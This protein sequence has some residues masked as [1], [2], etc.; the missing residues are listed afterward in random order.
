MSLSPSRP[1]PHRREMTRRVIRDRTGNVDDPT[2]PIHFVRFA[3]KK[4][5]RAE[6]YSV[7]MGRRTKCTD[8][9]IE[10]LST[11]IANGLS[12][13]DA[14]ALVDLTEQTLYQWFRRAAEERETFARLSEL[15]G[16]DDLGDD[17]RVEFEQLVER[18]GDGSA[19]VDTPF[20]R[21]AD[22][23][24]KAQPMFKGS[25]LAVVRR[26]ATES[27]VETRTT[28]EQM[29]DGKGVPVLTEQGE[30]IFKQTTVKIERPPHWQA[31]AWLLERKFPGEFGRRQAIDHSGEIGGLGSAIPDRF[32]VEFVAPTRGPD[33]Q[34]D[35]PADLPDEQPIAPA[36]D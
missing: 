29:V 11:Y 13:K 32:R 18:H 5:P 10:Q 28:T 30:P 34:H 16:R 23:V 22:A 8:E 31:A 15:R 9:R 6:C 12:N 26:G 36:G 4:R 20:Q 25:N 21:C 19:L 17:E 27:S 3:A 35:S 7:R 1:E 24:E 2:E 14:C 33:E